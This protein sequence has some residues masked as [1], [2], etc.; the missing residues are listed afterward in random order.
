MTWIMIRDAEFF[1]L[2]RDTAASVRQVKNVQ[3]KAR[4]LD[5][6]LAKSLHLL[7]IGEELRITLL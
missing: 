5:D 3:E 6:P 2:I 4:R 7:I 1:V